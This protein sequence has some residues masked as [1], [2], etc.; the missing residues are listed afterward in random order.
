VNT[1]TKSVR[2]FFSEHPHIPYSIYITRWE[3]DALG[4]VRRF[5]ANAGELVRIHVMGGSGTLF[6]VVNGSMGLPNVQ[7]AVYPFGSGNSFLRYFGKDKLHLF[8]SIR[9]QVYS[10]TIPMDALKCGSIYGV[11]RANTGLE[12]IA[13]KG[14]QDIKLKHPSFSE[15]LLCIWSG[16]RHVMSSKVLNNHYKVELDGKKLDGEYF[17]LLVANGPCF[18]QNMNPGVDAHPND[19][20]FDVYLINGITKANFA[21]CVPPYIYGNYKKLGGIV[22]HYR[23]TKI[24]ISSETHMTVCVDSQL[25]YESSV[26]IELVPYA[27]DFVCPGGID[28]DEIPRIYGRPGT[29]EKMRGGGHGN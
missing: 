9:S 8:A 23:G 18:G 5:A 28:L 21:P 26:D 4:V 29:S 20:V 17:S 16:F 24:S 27:V 7:L 22:E 10:S 12:A 19:G 1:L 13:D 15:D 6:E 2:A 3:R 25:L 11:V 14:G